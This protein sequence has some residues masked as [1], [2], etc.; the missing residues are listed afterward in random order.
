MQLYLI[1]WNIMLNSLNKPTATIALYRTH[2]KYKIS[3]SFP[4]DKLIG[5]LSLTTILNPWR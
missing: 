4:S 1:S 3:L 2:S 5:G